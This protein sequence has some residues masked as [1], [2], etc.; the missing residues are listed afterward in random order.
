MGFVRKVYNKA[1]NTLAYLSSKKYTTI[2]G[3]LAFF[4]ILSIVPFIFWLT[5]LFGNLNLDYDQIFSLSIFAGIRDVLS[6]FLEAAQSATAGAS[7]ILALT[8]LYSSTTLFYHMRRSGEIIYDY[9]RRKSGILLRVSALILLFVIMLLLF[10]EVGVFLFLGG[11]IRRLILSIVPFIF[12]LTLLFGNLNLDYDQIFSLSIFAGIRDVLSYFLEAAQSATAGASV[13]LALTTLYSSTTLFYHMRRSG[14]IIYDY[15]RRKSGILLRVSALILLFVIMLLLFAEVGVFLFL[16]GFIR[17]LFHTVF[18]Q[19]AV[20][21]ILAGLAFLLVLIL[22]LHVCPYRVNLKNVVW[23]SLLTVLMGGVASFGFS[24]YLSL[25]S[26]EKLYGA[27]TLLIVFL[28]WVYILMI[29]FVTGVIVN[30][31]GLEKEGKSGVAV[32]KF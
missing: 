1:K 3:T 32:K 15:R 24:L 31:H 12:W 19:I 8:T 21:I 27:I 4:L 13:I 11:F 10:A 29:C 22:N 9:R 5:L 7:V 20:Y 18:A 14:E 2:A 28:L 30:C 6:Y 17:R 26:M 16:G 23:G 25:S